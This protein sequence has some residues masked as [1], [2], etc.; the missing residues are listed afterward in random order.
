MGLSVRASFWWLPVLWKIIKWM[1]MRKKQ[2]DVTRVRIREGEELV[3]T[4]R[5]RA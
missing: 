4:R 2:S 3:I 1:K 5:G